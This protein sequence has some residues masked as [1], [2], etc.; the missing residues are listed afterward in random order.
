MNTEVQEAAQTEEQTDE[1][2]R[3]N[4][5]LL[6]KLGEE[7]Y[8]VNIA[9]VQA[10]EEMQPIIAVPDMPAYIKGVI[11]LRGKVIP[12]VDLR[13]NF[14]MEE[15][16]YDSRT[17]MIIG[18]VDGKHIG[19]IVDTVSEVE[20]IPESKISPPPEFESGSRREQFIAGIGM[21]DQQVRI[22]LDISKLFGQRELDTMHKKTEER[23]NYATK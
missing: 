4:K 16:E 17:C 2:V 6:F 5:Y 23:E 13:L 21:V 7:E 10:I 3:E 15:R 20:E 18:M 14:N 12:V 19:L 1:Q 8:G 9:T 11:N 22:L